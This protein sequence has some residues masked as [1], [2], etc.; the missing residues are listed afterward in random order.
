MATAQLIKRLGDRI[1]ERAGLRLPDWVIAARL[2]DR[3]AALGLDDATTYVDL[4]TSPRG[5]RELDHLLE[6]VRVG[7]TRFFRHQS[8]LRALADVVIP[9]L[10]RGGRR[11]VRAWSA[12][13]AS[14][15]EAYTLAMVLSRGL[16]SAGIDLE[17]LASDMSDDALTIARERVYPASALAKVPQKW[18]ELGF[19]R[20]DRDRYRISDRI[21]DLVSFERRNLADPSYPRGFDV[22]FCRNVLIYFTPEARERVVNR[23]VD[24]LL[25]EGFLF[26]GY[27]ENLR[28][29]DQV[30]AVRTPDAVL[31]RKISA[32]SAPAPK[33]PRPRRARRLTPAPVLKVPIASQPLP[34]S[35][36]AIIAEE[37]LVQLSG[38][39]TDDARLAREV[40]AAI[41][42]PYRRVIIDIDGAEYL[43]DEA[44]AVLKRARSA[45]RAA[46]IEL[47]IHALRSGTQRW[48]RR[49]GLDQ[50]AAD[51]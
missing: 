9:A 37:A 22:I 5:T 10:R 40:S 51:E 38:R 27:A 2:S 21:A 31:Y 39:Y 35:N 41:A 19:A 47:E 15:E 12:G 25:D 42:G 34:A 18:R 30:D 45:A 7:E 24:S 36:P 1:A 6:A 29:F 11:K 4:V 23:L 49:W 46:D 3:V 32:T 16:A 20:H 44:A 14:G 26:V 17:V 8:H 50:E 43:C 28:D 48:L 13:C 33:P